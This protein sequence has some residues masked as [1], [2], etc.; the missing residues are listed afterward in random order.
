MSYGL[1]HSVRWEHKLFPG[2]C[3]LSVLLLLGGSIHTLREFP[4]MQKTCWKHQR[5]RQALYPQC[6]LLARAWMRGSNYRGPPLTSS[7]VSSTQ[8][9]G[10]A[11]LVSLCT[12]ARNTMKAGGWR[13]CSVQSSRSVRSNS[14]RPHESQQSRPPCPSPTPGVHSNSCPS[15]R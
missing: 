5:T 4:H 8:E 9:D 7:F 6:S 14:L 2:F 1:F 10:W 15:S 13:D 11:P 3:D 12:A